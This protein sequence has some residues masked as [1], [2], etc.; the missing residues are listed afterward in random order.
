MII[1]N[2][3]YLVMKRRDP[4]DLCSLFSTGK[5]VQEVSSST[6]SLFSRYLPRKAAF[7]PD[8]KKSQ[9]RLVDSTHPVLKSS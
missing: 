4:W 9:A 7:Q 1:K 3:V 5:K 8:K 6:P 2:L